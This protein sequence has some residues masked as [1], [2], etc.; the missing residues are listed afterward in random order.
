MFSPFGGYMGRTEEKAGELRRD[1]ILMNPEGILLKR[2]DFC[3]EG[4]GKTQEGQTLPECGLG[5]PRGERA[6]GCGLESRAHR[7]GSRRTHPAVGAG[8]A[9]EAQSPPLKGSLLTLNWAEK[10]R[11]KS[12]TS[13]L[14][15]PP[16]PCSRPGR[17]PSPRAGMLQSQ[18]SLASW[19]LWEPDSIFSVPVPSSCTLR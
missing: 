18:A 15:V 16:C 7:P 13:P 8:E 9:G 19:Q 2:C 1:R 12:V 17:R 5:R 4:P 6:A 11:A 3:H 14:L 10:E